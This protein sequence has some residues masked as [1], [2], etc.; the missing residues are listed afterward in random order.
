MTEHG[1]GTCDSCLIKVNIEGVVV[2]P[3]CGQ[4]QQL[5]KYCIG[6]ESFPCR[7][8]NRIISDTGCDE[9]F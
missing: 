8:C 2:C 6:L 3:E 1:Y 4:S 9:E 7:E 5:C